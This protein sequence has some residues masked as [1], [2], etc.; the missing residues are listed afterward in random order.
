MIIT[1]KSLPRRTFLRGMGTTLALPL[2]DAMVP[3]ASVLAQT[4]AAPAIRMGFIYSPHGVIQDQWVPTT[5][6]AGFDVPPILGPIASFRDQL[7][8][9]SGLAHRQADS[10]GDGNGDHQRSTAV[11]LSGEHAWERRVQADA[12]ELSL[13]TTADQLAARELGKYT[14]LPSIELTLETPT[15]IACDSGDCFYS[16]TLSWR[17][18]TTPLPM[19]PHPRM[20]FERLFGEGGTAAEQSAQRRQTGSILDSVR[21]EAVRIQQSLGPQDRTKLS[22][23]LEA[24]RDIE[25]QI[26]RAEAAGSESP[27][28]LPDRPVD[29]PEEFGDHAKLMFDLQVLAFQAD[30]TRV[31]SLMMARELSPR[32]YPEIGVTGQHHQVSHHR[33]APD[34][35]SMKAKIDTYHISLLGYFLEKLSATPDGDGS[36]LDHVMILYGSGMGNGNL[37]EHTNLP[38]L[39]AGGGAG[40]LRTGRHLAYPEDTPKSNL[41]VTLLDKAGVE[42]EKIGDSTGQLPL[43]RLSDV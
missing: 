15:A 5:V 16:N 7:L 18:P 30:I 38:A 41:L 8:V 2:L 42:V 36:L 33:N 29:I 13:G 32:T 25:Q 26:Q 14:V 28:A 6:G 10:L 43:Q 9:V 23:Y 21:G 34:L 39:V 3:A 20:V 4:S 27:I 40:R 1:K 11:W 31:A 17:T 22:E 37:H 24:V 12:R 19:E 35:I